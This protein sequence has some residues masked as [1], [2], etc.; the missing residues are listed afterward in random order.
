[1]TNGFVSV[2]T[3]EVQHAMDKDSY[4][5]GANDALDGIMLLDLE[6]RLQGRIE[7]GKQ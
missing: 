7:I 6:Q 5:K 1:M 2:G 4:V 3:N